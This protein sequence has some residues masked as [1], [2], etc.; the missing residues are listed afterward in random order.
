MTSSMLL[1]LTCGTISYLML[2]RPLGASRRRALL[3]CDCRRTAGAS[4][5]TDSSV[6]MTA[7][8]EMPTSW[9]MASFNDFCAS[10]SWAK[11]SGS[12]TSKVSLPWT[13]S[14]AAAEAAAAA[15]TAS[16]RVVVLVFVIVVEVVVVKV[17]VV[18]VLVCV[19]VEV[20]VI[21]VVVVMVVVMGKPF[22]SHSMTGTS[23]RM[24]FS[25]SVALPSHVL[26]PYRAANFVLE[27]SFC[28]GP[29][30]M[31]SQALHSA[32]SLKTQLTGHARPGL[33]NSSSCGWPL[34]G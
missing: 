19:T 31:A 9:A 32:Q 10:G 4:G 1:P 8:T 7:S 15:G 20:E 28:A 30:G 18:L 13:D 22:S 21:V 16:S 3:P 29:Q 6:M 34:H 5:S 2:T 11:A 26:P 24:Q 12:D 33:Q 17:V 25:T 14:S 27:R 23:A